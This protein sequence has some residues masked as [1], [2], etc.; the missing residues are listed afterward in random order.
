MKKSFLTIILAFSAFLSAAAQEQVIEGLS[1]FLPKTALK[2]TLMVEKTTFTPGELA[3]YANRYL[4]QG[5]EVLTPSTTYSIINMRIDPIGVPDKEF[6]FTANATPKNSIQKLYTTKDGVLLSVNTKP[7][8]QETHAPFVPAKKP[9]P[10]KPRDFMT[11]EML[12]VG[13]QAKLAQLCSKE[14]YDI[15]DS[16]NEISRG[17]AETM[18]KDGEQ[19]RLMLNEMNRQEQAL[20]SLFNGTT[21]KDTMEVEII[22]CENDVVE[23]KVLFRFSDIYGVCDADDL[24]GVPYY[25]YIKDLKQTPEDTRTEKEI[26]KAKDETGL[27]VAIPG[28]AQV[29]IYQEERKWVEKEYSYAQ[30][31][32]V[33]N[34]SASLFTKKLHTTYHVNPVTGAMM[35]LESEELGK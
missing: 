12:S 31:G 34:V 9:T 28:R 15:R 22:C 20:T 32:R 25:I 30:F 16:R 13:S 33:E 23:K 11:Q 1:Y 35:Q 29:S 4:M 27:Y 7:N 5:D 21:V 17:Q 6:H 24:T 19:L 8:E 2:F 10:L 14:I 26:A 3:E 18:P